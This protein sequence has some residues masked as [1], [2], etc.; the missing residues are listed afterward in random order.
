M[1][2][3]KLLIMKTTDFATHL[4][5]FISK[6]LAVERGFSANTLTAYSHTFLLLIHFMDEKKKIRLNNLSLEK[7]TKDTIIDFLDYLRNARKCCSSTCNLRLAAIHSFY[8]YL[9]YVEIKNLSEIQRILAIKFT[10]TGHKQ[11]IFLTIDGIRLL[12]K[13]PDLK[14]AKGRRDLAL[15]SLTYDTA[16][17]VQEVIDLTPARIR[18]DK[19]SVI[20]LVGKGNKERIVPML[21]QQVQL[22]KMYMAENNLNED[23]ARS[24]PLFFNSRKEKLTRAGI[25]FI[26]SKYIS[27]AKNENS[28]LIPDGITCHSL[29]HSKA[30]HM[31]E[32][33]ARLIDIRDILGH[34][35]VVTTEIYARVDLNQK[36]I[37]LEKA[38]VDFNPNEKAKW[39]NDKNLVDWLK[40]FI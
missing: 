33:G 31:L 2:S 30:M 23:F 27:M 25:N 11:I 19:P 6:Y 35:S 15:L 37:A 34:V 29:R 40:K 20:K 1:Y 21:S 32:A 13:Q 26:L 17:R 18:L 9:Q 28:L 4:T 12:L 38:Y 22:L 39:I 10:R 8:K 24:S 3:P 5:N 14:T 36:R 16:A 7:I